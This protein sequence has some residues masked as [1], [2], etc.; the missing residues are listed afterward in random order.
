M[1]DGIFCRKPYIP[2]DAHP[3]QS[4]LD[5][6]MGKQTAVAMTDEDEAAFLAFMRRTDDVRILEMFAPRPEAFEAHAFAPREEGHGS[7]LLWNTRFPYTPRYGRVNADVTGPRQGWHYLA[8]TSEA[9]LIEYSRHNFREEPG[10]MAGRI[11]WV[12][13]RTRTGECAYDFEEFGRWYDSVVR[14]IRKQGRQRVAGAYNAYYLPD[15]W[16]KY[17]AAR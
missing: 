15:A 11:Y 6:H 4:G 3:P 17:G 8:N 5:D 12:K 1:P 2:K 7:Y 10:Y 16:A 14:W 9:P 13:G